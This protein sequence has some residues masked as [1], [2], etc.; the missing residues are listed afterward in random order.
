MA[1]SL[2]DGAR[3]LVDAPNYA[4]VATIQPDG[5]PQ[6]TVVWVKRDGDDIL[7]S[8]TT[9]RRKYDNLTRDPRA[10]IL[11]YAQD[12]PYSYLEVR[13][14]VTTT[15]EGGRELIDELA[16]KYMGAERYTMDDGT[17]NVR[18]VV[19]ISPDKVVFQ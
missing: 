5:Q 3:A 6:L 18:V 11:I 17:D 9:N 8:T 16:R 7:F 2:P 13:G 4:T 14:T 15:E 10:S 1:Q 19:R 12:N